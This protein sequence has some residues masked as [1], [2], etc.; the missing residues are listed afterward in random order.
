[1]GEGKSWIEHFGDPS[2]IKD[3]RRSSEKKEAEIAAAALL[4][5][6]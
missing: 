2:A 1:M 4:T 6:I 3:E 5:R